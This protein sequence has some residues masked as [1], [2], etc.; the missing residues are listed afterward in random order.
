MDIANDN[1]KNLIS[2]SFGFYL[3]ELL[4]ADYSG[5]YISSFELR[6]VAEKLGVEVKLTDNHKMFGEILKIAKQEGRMGEALELIKEL[7][8]A[9]IAV[10]DELAA[11]FQKAADPIEEW[12]IKAKRA[13]RKIENAIKEAKNESIS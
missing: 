7:F 12:Q 5:V 2:N 8:S 9:R 3:Y 11:R 10:Y 6:G 1:N 13:L 4:G